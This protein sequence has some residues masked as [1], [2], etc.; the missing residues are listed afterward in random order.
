M[1]AKDTIIGSAKDETRP[2]TSNV[3]SLCTL[4]K[5]EI[6]FPAKAQRRKKE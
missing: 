3:T 2:I 4:D 1:A 6:C 5:K